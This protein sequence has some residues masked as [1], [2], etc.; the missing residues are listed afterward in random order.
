MTK[1]TTLF[2]DKIYQELEKRMSEQPRTEVETALSAIRSDSKLQSILRKYTKKYG[3]HYMDKFGCYGNYKERPFI[4][5]YKGN[6]VPSTTT[7]LYMGLTSTENIMPIFLTLVKESR[8]IHHIFRL[9]EKAGY[10]YLKSNPKFTMPN[11]DYVDCIAKLNNKRITS[12]DI[13]DDVSSKQVL[14]G[15]EKQV[16]RLLDG[17]Q[18][19]H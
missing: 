9:D 11:N 10:F 2:R 15:L 5:W 13:F 3:I 14:K 6:F 17:K 4:F 1:Q 18:H 16:Q 12:L 8:G 19:E 7:N